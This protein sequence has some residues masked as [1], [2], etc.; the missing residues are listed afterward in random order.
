M[1]IYEC[2]RLSRSRRGKLPRREIEIKWEEEE[3]NG[4]EIRDKR[5]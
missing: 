1:R 4:I 3:D 2:N 5:R